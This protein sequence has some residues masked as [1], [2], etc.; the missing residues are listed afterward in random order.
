MKVLFIHG[1]ASSG[2]YK[3]ASSLRILLKGSEVIAPDV[4]IEPGEALA[5][6]EGICRDERPDLI[7]GLSLGGFWAQKLRGFRKILVNPDFHIS[8]LLRTKVGECEYLSPRRDGALTFT[9]TEAICDEYV[10]LEVV[11]FDGL[12]AVEAALTTGMFA[13]R[14]EMVDCK[15]EFE[16]HYP[17]RSH[18]YPGTHLPNYPEIKK[19]I[20]PVIENEVPHQ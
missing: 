12:D 10:G 3:M 6:L 1:L 13:D 11:Q 2:A 15:D 8:R 14:D 5:M 4:P 16:E 20:I 18:S 7:V 9:V 17:G 19:Y